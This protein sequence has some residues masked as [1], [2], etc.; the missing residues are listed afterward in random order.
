[1]STSFQ[2]IIPFAHSLLSRKIS[3]GDIAID[4]TVGNGFDTLL[5]A[6][7]VGEEGHV[8]GFDIQQS[9]LDSTMERLTKHDLSDRVS[10][11]RKGHEYMVDYLPRDVHG[12]IVAI[13]FNLGY[14]PG[15]DKEVIT[16]PETTIRALESSVALLESNGLITVVCYRGHEGGRLESQAV[17]AWARLLPAEDFD[18][19][20]YEQI[21]RRDPPGLIAIQKLL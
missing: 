7:L 6:N 19:L 12:R 8:W 21:N 20:S 13:T 9:A 5:L 11:L 16:R 1:M 10:L 3:K 17:E 18:V 2:R 14:L 15:G 4:A